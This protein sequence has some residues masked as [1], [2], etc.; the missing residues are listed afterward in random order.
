MN[1][2]V[3]TEFLS[4]SPHVYSLNH[5]TPNKFNEVENQEQEDQQVVANSE[6]N[7]DDYVI[8]IDQ[9]ISE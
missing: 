3:M 4:L 6:I 1:T 5:Q 9:H 2:L 7:H 8:V